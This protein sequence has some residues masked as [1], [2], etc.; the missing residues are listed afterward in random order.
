MSMRPNVRESLRDKQHG[1]RW[2]FV[3]HPKRFTVSH[4]FRYSLKFQSTLCLVSHKHKSSEKE[5]LKV[6]F[7]FSFPLCTNARMNMVAWSLKYFFWFLI[8]FGYSWIWFRFCLLFYFLGGNCNWINVDEF[9][10][11]IADDNKHYGMTWVVYCTI[12]LL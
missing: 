10:Y 5:K 3:A 4:Y 7:C 11:I 8:F 6:S 1:K 9:A 2:R 12:S